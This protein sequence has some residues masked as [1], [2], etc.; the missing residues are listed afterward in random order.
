ML[1]YSV[2]FIWLNFTTL[3]I[4]MNCNEIW[5]VTKQ[6]LKKI[7]LQK[8]CLIKSKRGS[9]HQGMCIALKKGWIAHVLAFNFTLV[10]ISFRLFLSIFL[11]FSPVFCLIVD[12]WVTRAVIRFIFIIIIG[13]LSSIYLYKCFFD[14]IKD[15]SSVTL[16]QS[17]ELREES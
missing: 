1:L 10:F 3:L 16:L 2:P 8:K 11:Y 15:L 9:H 6:T 7:V 4:Y 17:L 5:N 12:C 14:R 13:Y